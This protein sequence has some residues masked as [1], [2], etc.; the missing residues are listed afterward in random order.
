MHVGLAAHSRHGKKLLKTCLTCPCTDYMRAGPTP[1]HVLAEC[2]QGSEWKPD[3]FWQVMEGHTSLHTSIS[4]ML[5]TSLPD[6]LEWHGSQPNSQMQPGRRL[7]PM[8]A[9]HVPLSV[10]SWRLSKTI[11]WA[12]SCSWKLRDDASA[13]D[14][15]TEH[16]SVVGSS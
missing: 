5:M 12:G 1:K 2:L 10:L 8:Q 13:G 15:C 4:C 3:A 9:H 14:G 6:G 16:A 11:I 7:D